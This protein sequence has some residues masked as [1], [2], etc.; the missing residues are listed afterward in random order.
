MR[1]GI[2]GGIAEGKSTVLAYLASAGYRTLSSDAVAREVF[3]LP[4]TQEGLAILLGRQGPVDRT[5]VRTALASAPEMRRKI[6][7]LTHSQIRSR[8]EAS[9]AQFVE[10]P[11]IVETCI[12]D[13]FD[14]VWVVTCGEETQ[15]K[16]LN[17]RFG[18]ARLSRSMIAAQLP[19]RVKIPFGH[20]LI[21]TNRAESDVSDEALAHARRVF[22]L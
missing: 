6:N 1:I 4:E 19:T 18:N 20:V 16:R 8:I 11:L 9:D 12:Q 13:R 15:L 7:S 17:E 14:E 3:D 10:T 21:R 2:T 22:A 5:E